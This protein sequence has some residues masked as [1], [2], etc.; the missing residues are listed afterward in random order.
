MTQKS[1]GLMSDPTCTLPSGDVF[2]KIFEKIQTG[3]LIIDPEAH[4]I[5]DANPLA[6]FITGR[7]KEELLGS[8]CH[9]FLCPV[10]RGECPT[11]DL[12]QEVRNLEQVIINKNDEKIPILKTVTKVSIN[13]REYLIESF[14]DILDRK[15]AEER[16]IA[17]IAYLSESI[18]RVKKPLELMHEDFNQLAVLVSGSDYDAEDIRMQLQLHANNLSQIVKNLEELQ[19]KAVGEKP[20][21]IP[22]EFR[23][24]LIE[25]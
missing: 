11:T 12:H 24:F 16:H 7:S 8:V 15:K 23:D 19:A 5:V 10:K 21:D 25:K 22:P 9:E 1:L 20:T 18:L 14:I 6:E 13:R 4:R 3:I 17:L 2:R